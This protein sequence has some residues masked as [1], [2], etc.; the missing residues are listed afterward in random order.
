MSSSGKRAA[1][2]KYGYVS[3]GSSRVNYGVCRS[4]CAGDYAHWLAGERAVGS[5]IVVVFLVVLSLDRVEPLPAVFIFLLAAAVMG[6]CAVIT[7]V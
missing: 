4:G 1:A 7:D 2:R 5:G 6:F 3:L